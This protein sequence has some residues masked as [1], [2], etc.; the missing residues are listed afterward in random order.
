MAPAPPAPGAV[1]VHVANSTDMKLQ[2]DGRTFASTSTSTLLTLSPSS[3]GTCNHVLWASQAGT[4]FHMFSREALPLGNFPTR[5]SGAR[6]PSPTL[7]QIHTATATLG[8]Q[9]FAP[10]P[11]P[12]PAPWLA[13]AP[14]CSLP[15]STPLPSGLSRFL[16]LLYQ[17]QLPHRPLLC[18]GLD[19]PLR[20]MVKEH[21]FDKGHTFESG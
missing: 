15:Y 12:K 2:L 19:P 7:H 10:A 20:K 11:C 3:I 17:S 16:L 13:Y 8:D 1:V 21:S 14:G 9:P 6:C 5:Y 18:P 4:P